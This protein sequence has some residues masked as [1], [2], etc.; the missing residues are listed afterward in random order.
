MFDP[1]KIGEALEELKRLNVNLEALHQDAEDLK[2][3]KSDLRLLI[4]K[5]GEIQV[6][7]KNVGAAA[8]ELALLNRILL[9][10]KKVSG[11]SGVVKHILS[12]LADM[13]TGRRHS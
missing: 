6:G 9:S 13:A 1:E 10:I 5:L 2:P 3:M 8:K 4:A 11:W 12:G 7:A